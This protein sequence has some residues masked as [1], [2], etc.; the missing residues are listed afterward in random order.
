MFS[1]SEKKRKKTCL[2]VF[3]P[4]TKSALLF[5]PLLWPSSLPPP[6]GGRENKWI[7]PKQW[8]K[9][10]AANKNKISVILLLFKS[11][12]SILVF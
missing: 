12:F 4:L 1:L 3:P 6:G 7:G 11:L 2:W 5:P 8:V 9:S 10:R